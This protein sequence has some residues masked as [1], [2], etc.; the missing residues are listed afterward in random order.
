MKSIK[1][2]FSFLDAQTPDLSFISQ[3]GISPHIQTIE[4]YFQK[5]CQQI[6]KE[7]A[8]T[9]AYLYEEQGRLTE[10]QTPYFFLKPANKKG[11]FFVLAKNGWSISFAE[12]IVKDNLFIRDRE[13]WDQVELFEPIHPHSSL[14]IRSTYILDNQII[15]YPVYE[16]MMIHQLFLDLL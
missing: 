3:Y 10:N 2:I 12:R 8:I 13:L 15:S 14:R 1:K 4:L 9:N 7:I 6:K 16:K 11:F 5:L